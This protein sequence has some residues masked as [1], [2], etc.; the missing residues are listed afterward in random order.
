MAFLLFALYMILLYFFAFKITYVMQNKEWIRVGIVVIGL[1]LNQYQ[2]F[3]MPICWPWII[4]LMIFYV[5]FLV[6]IDNLHIPSYL[7]LS[8]LL[9]ISPQIFSLGFILPIGLVL[10]ILVTTR[11]EKLTIKKISLMFTSMFS[12]LLSYFIF[13]QYLFHYLCYF[14]YFISLCIVSLCMLFIY[15]FLNKE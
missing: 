8:F 4:S 10:I 3:V 12:V 1:N 11:I 6:P 2:N 15:T 5:A 7:F 9:L 13:H 14:L